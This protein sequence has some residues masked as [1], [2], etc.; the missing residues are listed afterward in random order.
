MRF[1]PNLPNW[2]NVPLAKLL[3][4]SL[5]LPA[6][7]ENDVN[8]GTLGEYTLGAGQGVHSLVGIFVGTGIG[9]GLILDDK[10]GTA[11]A[12]G[13]GRGG[14]HGGPGRGAGLWL[15]QPRLRRGVGQPNRHRAGHLGRRQGRA[16]EP[17][18]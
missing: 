1:A 15:R 5:E 3:S 17:D 7:V 4:D 12:G 16:A 2:E 13:C 8:L 9:G 18:P 6:F 10:L 14:P 11:G